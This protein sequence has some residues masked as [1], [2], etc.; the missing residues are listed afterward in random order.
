M[1]ITESLGPQDKEDETTLNAS[2][3]LTLSDTFNTTSD[4]NEDLLELYTDEDSA[5]V[6]REDDLEAFL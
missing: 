6:A 3:P 4:S 1:E 5:E 2:E